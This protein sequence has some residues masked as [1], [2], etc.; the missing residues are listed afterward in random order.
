MEVL[1]SERYYNPLER[2]MREHTDEER[3]VGGSEGVAGRPVAPAVAIIDERVAGGNVEVIAG[4]V[5]T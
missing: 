4:M 1:P 2:K 3:K 5:E